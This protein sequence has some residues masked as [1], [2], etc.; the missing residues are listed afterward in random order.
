VPSSNVTGLRPV[1]GSVMPAGL[2]I[3]KARLPDLCA[4]VRGACRRCG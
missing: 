4:S 2:V 1:G 3:P